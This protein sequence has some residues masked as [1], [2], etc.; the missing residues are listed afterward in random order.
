MIVRI[1]VIMA[2]ATIGL[3]CSC[4]LERGIEFTKKPVVVSNHESSAP[5]TCYVDFETKQKYEWVTF[6]MRDSG[7]VSK[8]SYMPS[9]K[10]ETG[11]LLMLMR[12]DR[13]H[14]ISIELTDN[15]GKILKYDKE[16]VFNTLPLPSSDIEFP[17][18]QITKLSSDEMEE[19]FTIF[20]P[21]R[22]VP[23][24]IPGA[25]ELNKSFGMLV[26][27]DHRGEVF[28]YYRT[29][30]RISDF[31]FLPNG[32][33]SYM[34]QDSKIAEID[35]AGN[36][37][38]EWYAANRPE[39]KD[40]RAIPVKTLTFH[41]DAALMPNGFWLALSS[42]IREVDNYY[43]SEKD[44]NAPRKS[45]KVMGDVVVEFTPEGEIVHQ[46]RAFDYMP[47]F[48]I[49]YET[50]SG[51]WE[52]RGFPGVIDWS[53]ANAIVP[54]PE[55]NA[56]LINFR[57]QSAMIK[58]DKSSNQ[59]KWIFAEPSGWGEGLEE[60][61]LELPSE[62]WCWHQHSPN[63]TSTGNL[64]FF[65][66]NNYQS[67]PFDKS[68]KIEESRS[69][70]IEYR[71][72]EE[73]MTVEKIWTSEIPNEPATASI[74]MGSASELPQ[75]GNILAGYGMI[76]SEMPGEKRPNQLVWTMVREFK[77]TTPAE[78]VWEMRLISR[79]D[80]SSVGWTLF[81]AKRIK[82]QQRI[83]NKNH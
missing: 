59:I 62:N 6:T 46:W 73:K 24:N 83:A 64:L 65:N 55:E 54:I 53:H 60:K 43:T 2:I 57:Y 5:L 10:K 26:I 63:F 75:K 56:F 74:A 16:L 37:I 39:G 4:D 70:V 14:L 44:A 42:E 22:R 3:A 58:I 18:I 27:V 31:D 23:Q 28:W 17:R 38:H 80:N 9:D 69:H 35:F 12:P 79:T 29:N 68:K 32:N 15:Q 19:G 13:E 61:L 36:I 49:G 52:R 50:F 78:I 51:Y 77:H 66:N 71:I 67:R 45:Q 41:H 21:R 40:D 47:V 30:S 8:L 1:R 33:I 76:I 11:Y 48:R 72:D 82:I 81:G 25:N 20:N 34:T 7:R